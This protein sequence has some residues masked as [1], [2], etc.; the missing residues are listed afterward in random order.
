MA[1]VNSKENHWEIRKCN[2]PSII[3]ELM[4]YLKE[5]FR[6]WSG[7]FKRGVPTLKCHLEHSSKTQ[8]WHIATLQRRGAKTPA[9]LLLERRVTLPPI[10]D[11]DLCEPIL[12]KANEKTKTVPV[13]FIIRKGVNT[14]FI[15][16]ENSTWTILVSDNRIARLD[17]DVKTEPA[18][19]ETICESELQPQNTVVEPS[20]EQQQLK[21]SEPSRT[22][23]RNRKQPDR[24]GEPIPT[25]LIKKEGGCDCGKQTSWNLEV[26]LNFRRTK[27]ELTWRALSISN[28]HKTKINSN[29]VWRYH[30]LIDLSNICQK[31]NSPTNRNLILTST[32]LQLMKSIVSR[33]YMIRMK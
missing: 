31:K 18:V 25:N 6:Q 1:I 14:S 2:H 13:T 28:D 11:F 32:D 17:D 30:Y 9:E 26:L 15:Q 23:T 7:H 21:P 5:Q 22:S 27:E 3:Q 24:F 12:F 20:A 19:E 10:A 8:W 29:S 33:P 4:D 16:P